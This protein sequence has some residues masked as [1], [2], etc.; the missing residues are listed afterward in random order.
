M[1]NIDQSEAEAFG[2]LV[3]THAYA[4]G[5]IEGIS[6]WV[7]IKIATMFEDEFKRVVIATAK[8][9]VEKKHVIKHIVAELYANNNAGSDI[10]PVLQNNFMKTDMRD[11][12]NIIAR[13]KPRLE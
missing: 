11:F 13:Q 1:L 2:A 7:F 3:L 8:L 12:I 4:R 10:S 6:T 5:S 9:F